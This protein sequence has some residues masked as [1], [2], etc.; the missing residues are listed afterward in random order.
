[1]KQIYLIFILK[2][3]L[4]RGHNLVITVTEIGRVWLVRIV[5]TVICKPSPLNMLQMLCVCFNSM[6]SSGNMECICGLLLS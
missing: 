5:S 3:Y 1:M 4:L 6:A 2:F